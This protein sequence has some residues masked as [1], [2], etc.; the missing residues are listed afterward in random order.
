MLR[1]GVS[2]DRR[3]LAAL[4]GAAGCWGLGTVV[5]KQGEALKIWREALKEHPTNELL[6]STIKR[7]STQ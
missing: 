2:I 1:S 3:D 7:F 5:S 4:V 6:Q